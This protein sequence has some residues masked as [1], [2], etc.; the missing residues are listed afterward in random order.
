MLRLLIFTTS[1]LFFP[2]VA[3]SQPGNFLNIEDLQRGIVEVQETNHLVWEVSGPE[4]EKPTYIYG[5]LK[6]VPGAHFFLPTELNACVQACDKWLMEINPYSLELDHLYRGSTPH[7]S[8]L[9]T[10]YKKKTLRRF[11]Q[12]L[13]DSTTIL[14]QYQYQLRYP[15]ALLAQQVLA[16]YCLRR[17]TSYEPRDYEVYLYENI[18]K[19]FQSLEAEW[20][21]TYS[22]EGLSALEQADSLMSHWEKRG[23]LDQ[24][25]QAL[26][27]AYRAGDLDA[28]EWLAMD[29]PNL[30]DNLS[31]M[32]ASRVENWLKALK[33]SLGKDCMLLAKTGRTVRPA[34]LSRWSR[35]YSPGS[36]QALM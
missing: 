30:G 15:H 27:D 25:F 9:S 13:T 10:F 5:I 23:E 36:K 18:Q 19:P 11:E 34:F 32:K 24:R 29:A 14:T 6:R 16:D 1:F 22:V 33:W 35:P 4:M 17:K 8:T 7:D 20:S 21:R 2:V 26:L 3:W 31:Y 28:V 12:Y